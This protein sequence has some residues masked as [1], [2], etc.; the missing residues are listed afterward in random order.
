MNC[1]KHPE[2]E[3]RIEYPGGPYPRTGFCIKCPQH[4]PLCTAVRFMNICLRHHGH[5]GKHKDDRGN[6]WEDK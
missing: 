6:E 3:L 5:D 1:P 2:V 4:Y